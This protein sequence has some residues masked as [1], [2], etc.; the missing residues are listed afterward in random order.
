MD[1]SFIVLPGSVSVTLKSGDNHV[2]DKSHPN[3]KLVLEA[4]KAKK[5]SKLESLVNIPKAISVAS[6]GA[7]TVDGG[8]V[9]YNGKV[10]HSYLAT[11]IL[12]ILAQGFDVT[13]WTRFMEKL[14]QNPSH[15]AVNELYQFLER[16]KLPLT[17]DGDFLAYKNVR[18]DYK[19]IHSGTFDNRVGDKPRMNRNEVDEDKDRTCS[20]GLHFCS[21]GYLPHFSAGVNG[22]TMIVKVNPADVVSIPA[23]HNAE[24]ARGVGYEVVGEIGVDLEIADM[25]RDTVIESPV[26][27]KAKVNK[28]VA[29]VE[30][31]VTKR[32]SAST[33]AT[34]KAL[35]VTN[36]EVEKAVKASK[37]VSY[38]APG[39]FPLSDR[40]IGV[41]ADMHDDN[42]F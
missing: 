6:K 19:D 9:R 15:R 42:E 8:E 1:I 32:G 29:R 22:R 2:I 20:K 28:L 3:Y 11:R 10:V 14:Y 26:I 7:V 21:K 5:Y 4:I 38:F 12:D 13:P 25:D 37:L 23:D 33:R 18:A 17:P 27:K 34:A 16:G 36:E 39:F 40:N 30:E 31:Y 41:T 24:K 35:K